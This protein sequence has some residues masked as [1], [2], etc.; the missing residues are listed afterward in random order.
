[1]Y[2]LPKAVAHLKAAPRAT[3][4]RPLGKLVDN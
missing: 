3:R 4:I 1:M 2:R